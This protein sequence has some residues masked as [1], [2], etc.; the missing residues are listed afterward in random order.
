MFIRSLFSCYAMQRLMK[1]NMHQNADSGSV[2]IFV[3]R[4]SFSV[5]KCKVKKHVSEGLF[6]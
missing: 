5:F 2:V 3:S 4:Y 1:K 6:N